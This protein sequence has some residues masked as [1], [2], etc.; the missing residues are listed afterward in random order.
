MYMS[1]LHYHSRV[2]VV[3]QVYIINR[4]VIP[5]RICIHS[6]LYIYIV[7][8]LYIVYTHYVQ[9]TIC[10]FRLCRKLI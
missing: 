9:Q 10:S 1:G 2:K 6:Y 7:G 3:Y 5:E 8:I 4:F